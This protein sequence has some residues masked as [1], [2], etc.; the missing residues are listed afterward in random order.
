LPWQRPLTD[1]ETNARLNIHTNMSTNP[2]NLVKVGLAVSE[3]FFAPSD[4][5]MEERKKR[6]QSNSSTT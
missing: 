4:R 2:E 5:K 6:K 3:I 1:P